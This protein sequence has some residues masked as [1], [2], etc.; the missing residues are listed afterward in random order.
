MQLHACHF[1]LHPGTWRQG[2]AQRQGDLGIVVPSRV[3]SWMSSW[4]FALGMTRGEF[5]GDL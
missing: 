1:H 3:G 4:N 5:R 2:H